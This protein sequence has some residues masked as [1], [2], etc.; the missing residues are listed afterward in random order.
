MYRVVETEEF[1]FW[2]HEQTLK[3]QAQIQ[4]RIFRVMEYGHF[5]IAKKIDDHLAELKWKN[6]LRVY[7]SVSLDPQ[8][9]VVVLLLGGNKNSQRADIVR[10]KSL[11]KKISE[12]K[13]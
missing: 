12:G 8:G 9:R 3:V 11:I 4:A 1:T 5:G 6:G 2:L 10:A 13:K 7:F